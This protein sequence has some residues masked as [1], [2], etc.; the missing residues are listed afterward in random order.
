VI[1]PALV[2]DE[3]PGMPEALRAVQYVGGVLMT[4]EAAQQLVVAAWFAAE[5][6]A[7]AAAFADAADM[8]YE[9]A[10]AWKSAEYHNAATVLDMMSHE[11][12]SPQ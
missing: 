9:W 3:I 12:R 7:R 10:D 8:F 11:M 4:P 5:P 6:A 2:I 1:A